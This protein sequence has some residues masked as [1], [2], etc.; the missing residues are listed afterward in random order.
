M[1]AAKIANNSQLF[2]VTL[3][4]RGSHSTTSS[5]TSTLSQRAAELRLSRFS[6]G[7]GMNR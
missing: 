7:A 4:G 3:A 2:S 6:N 5:V 1:V